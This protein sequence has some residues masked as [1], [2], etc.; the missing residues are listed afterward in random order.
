MATPT[1]R[2]T[3]RDYCMRRLGN[4]VINI[5][6]SQDQ[7]DDRIDD[8]LQ[9]Y[10]DYH[11]DGTEK[12]YY[13]Y[14]VTQDDID[15]KFITLPENIIGVSGIFP[16]GTWTAMNSIFSFQYQYALN[17]IFDLTSTELAPYFMA[18][19]Y[20]QMIEQ[21][22]VGQQ[23]LR[24]NRNNNKCFIDMDWSRVTT[25][26]YLMIEC[27]QVIDPDEYPNVWND[28]WLK[29]YATT[30]MRYQWAGNLGK[31]KDQTLPGGMK[32]NA[33]DIFAEAVR[34]KKRLE[35]ELETKY[36]GVLEFYEG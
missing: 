21:V 4:G 30:L 2:T 23:R 34:E 11:Y 10:L 12:A 24:F 1:D 5:E 16:L 28:R 6:I 18:M 19:Q 29:E 35:D 13:K 7:A 3:F 8:A 22:L 33:A 27:Y 20:L 32:F 9:M 14:K 17:N 26:Y 36:G 31:F 25:D 15:N